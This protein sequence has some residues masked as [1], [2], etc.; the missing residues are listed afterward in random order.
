VRKFRVKTRDQPGGRASVDVV[1]GLLMV[2][3]VIVKK[4]QRRNDREFDPRAE[5]P[6]VRLQTGGSRCS[7]SVTAKVW[8][9]RD[10][11]LGA[12]LSPN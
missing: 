7:D 5:G 12:A 2:K 10:S 6:Y 11:P 9:L 8:G 1:A 4:V 3:K